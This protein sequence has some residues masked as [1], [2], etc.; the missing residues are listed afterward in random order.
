MSTDTTTNT[1]ERQ[2]IEQAVQTY[3]DGLLRR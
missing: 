1:D 3:F 2:A